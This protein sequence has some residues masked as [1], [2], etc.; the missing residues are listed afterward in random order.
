MKK[1]LLS[2]T[3]L[4]LS[5]VCFAQEQEP[6]DLQGPTTLQKNHN[7]LSGIDAPNAGFGIKGGVNFANV[8]GDDADALDAISHTNFHAGIYAQFGISESFSL[9]LEGLYSR[10]GFETDVENRFDYLELP[11]LAVFNFS[12]NFSIHAGPQ[13]SIMVAAKQDDKEINM[14][15]LNTF[16]YGVAA[17]VEA[18]FRMFRLGA[19]Y[20]LGFAGLLDEGD[21]GLT[22][23]E[24]VKNNVAQLYVG[25]GF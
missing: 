17:G 24:D 18:R 3:M 12:D 23:G 20:N 13:M 19:R 7:L 15:D 9:Q 22:I 1:Y 14:E 16:D 11:L 6:E 21:T 4:L 5:L 2:A 10:K 25:I 8:Y